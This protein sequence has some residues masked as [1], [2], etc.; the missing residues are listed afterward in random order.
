MEGER[1]MRI[2]NVKVYGEDFHFHPGDVVIEDGLFCE[3]ASG[4]G[5]VVDGGGATPFRD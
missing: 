2:K 5:E 1:D 4:S 3:T